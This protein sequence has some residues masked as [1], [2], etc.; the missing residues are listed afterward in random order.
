M[1]EPW[2]R[3][4]FQPGLQPTIVACL[5][6]KK[7]FTREQAEKRRKCPKCKFYW[8]QSNFETDKENRKSM[9]ER[10]NRG[11]SRPGAGRPKTKTGPRA[12]GI[13]IG[14]ITQADRDYIN[15]TLTPGERHN[16]LLQAADRKAKGHSGCAGDSQFSGIT[17]AGGG[18]YGLPKNAVAKGRGGGLLPKDATVDDGE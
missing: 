4:Y 15:S 1:T 5:N 12:Q 9:N 8:N 11:G 3:W 17:V 14:E 16:A 13:W 18:G 7:E 2:K 6:C 10:T